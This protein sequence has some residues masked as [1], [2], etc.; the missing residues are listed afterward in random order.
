LGVRGHGGPERT[1]TCQDQGWE[2]KTLD[3][4]TGEDATTVIVFVEQTAPDG[5]AYADNLGLPR[6]PAAE[7][8]QRNN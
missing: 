2:R 6:S 1:V 4:T 5:Q 8:R 7:D 3:F